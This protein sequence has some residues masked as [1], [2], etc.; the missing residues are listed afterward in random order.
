MASVS[1]YIFDFDGVLADSVEVKTQ[2]FAEL[3]EP[4]GSEV[5]SLVME[6]HRNFGGMTRAEKFIHY[7]KFF[8]EEDLDRTGLDEMCARFSGLVKDNVTACAEIP[9]ASVF[10]T[11]HCNDVL[12]FIDSAT[13]GEELREI[14]SR[15]GLSKYFIEV[16]GSEQSKTENLQ[17][18]IDRHGLDTASC[19]FFGDAASDW[20]AATACGVPFVG[21]VPDSNA[22]LL[23]EAGEI[24]WYRDFIEF[25]GA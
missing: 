10:L 18:L 23:V 12:C 6:H 3:Y 9:G 5:V 2:A 7:H 14:V 22:P 24:L 21:I 11:R 19:L 13:P 25:M 8:L 17:S 1:A 4:Y 15:R 16:L 20:K